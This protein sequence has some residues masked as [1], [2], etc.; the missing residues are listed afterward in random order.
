MPDPLDEQGDDPLVVKAQ[1]NEYKQAS[2][3]RGERQMRARLNSYR[4]GSAAFR[5]VM[6]FLS[7]LLVCEWRGN[8]GPCFFCCAT[9]RFEGECSGV[10]GNLL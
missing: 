6:L 1:E 8:E 5:A 4:A 9:R 2:A 10:A 7:G 3:Q